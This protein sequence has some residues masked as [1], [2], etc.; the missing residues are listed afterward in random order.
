MLFVFSGMGYGVGNKVINVTINQKNIAVTQI[1]IIKDGQV[2]DIEY[3]SF[4]NIDRTLVPIRLTE[5][6]GAKVSWDQKTETVT[7]NHNNKTIKLTIDS[8]IVRVDNKTIKLDKNSI[9]RLV[10]FAN[11]DARTMV[12]LAFMSE[13]LGYDVGWDDVAKNAF[14]NTR[15]VS[16]PEEEKVEEEKIEAPSYNEVVEVTKEIVGGQGAI[17][18]NS[19]ENAKYRT[20]KLQGPE[21]IVIDLLGSTL[22]GSTFYELKYELGFIEGIRVAQFEP[23]KN[24]AA[25]DKIVRL[26][27][28]VKDGV[29]DSNVEIQTYE[30]KII[31]I[32]ESN[33]WENINYSG[34][35]RER[36]LII[37][38][39]KDTSYSVEYDPLRKKM[40][41]S[42]PKDA[43]SLVPGS[44]SVND[45]LV[46]EIKIVKNSD[47]TKLFIQFRRGIE[48]DLLSSRI[49]DKIELKIKRDLDVK[50]SERVIVIDP[51][52]GGR[53]PGTSSADQVREKDVVLKI[54]LKLKKALE[55][56]GYNIIM[57]R[58]K[59]VAVD[60]YSRAR[61][62]N[63]AFAD[64]FVSIHANAAI[65][66][67]AHGME[68]LYA[69]AAGNANKIEDQHPLSKAI[70]DE[71]VKATGA[72]RRNTVPRPNLVVLRETK[73]PATLVEVGFLSNVEEAKLIINDSYQDKIVDG[74][75]KGIE[76]YFD[77][78]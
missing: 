35:G 19:T 66:K 43:A 24:Y 4:V 54:S 73:M 37:E 46:D 71:M 32:P 75:V 18:I 28:D 72:H 68:V 48:Y 6:L 16:K 56:K 55:G 36:T 34:E 41:I 20:M 26:V 47:E 23:D 5:K 70:L 61:I 63:D 2:L 65:N 40:E 13:M 60:L 31:I 10:I 51:G 21:R 76:K 25:D 57:T 39:E 9:P 33:S 50:P 3:P 1:P 17:V 53:D 22:R 30:N 44:L 14:I 11:K 7:V 69:P 67:A 62:A 8:D 78:Y 45:G 29:L 59:D 38:N 77:E 52:H 64:I 74:I 12:P 27:I 58:D 42:I 15:K 49:D